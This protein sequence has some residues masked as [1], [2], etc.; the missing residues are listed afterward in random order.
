MLEI[1]KFIVNPFQLNAYVLYD[2]TR[3]C[4]LIDPAVSNTGELEELKSFISDNQLITQLVVNTHSHIDHIL[5][6]KTVCEAFG[7]PLYAHPDGQS[8][9]EHAAASAQ[10]FGLPFAG[11]KPIDVFIHEPQE[12][13]FGNTVLKVLDTPG[14][15]AGSICLY[16]EKE[17]VI[18]V[19]DV[20]FRESIGRTDLP[21]G[22]YDVL[23]KSIWEKL[24]VLPNET[25]VFP[26]HGPKTTIGY[27]KENNP[28][29]AIGME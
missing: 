17:G 10:K 26:G 24:F 2:E 25:V 29:V 19:G 5:G 14:H 20:L 27:E 18:V 6:N 28:F 9:L 21:T 15:A 3:E 12:L 4:I 23:Q 16:A 22:D 7:V 13:K 1:K 11:V 8:F